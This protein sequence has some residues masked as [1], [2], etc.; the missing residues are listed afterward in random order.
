[1]KYAANFPVTINHT[2]TISLL[3]TG[4]TI[5]CMSKSCFEKLH[6]QP[7]LVQT[8]TYRIHCADGN[9]LG[10]IG[11]TTCTLKFPQTPHPLH[12]H[13]GLKSI[14]RVDPAPFPLHVNQSNNIKK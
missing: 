2:R 13:Q 11:M 3:N 8:S 9:S 10:P 7:K 5:S 12:L 6:P 4:A 14:V 1:M